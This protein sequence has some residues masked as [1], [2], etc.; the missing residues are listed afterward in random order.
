MAL[1][2]P[3]RLLTVSGSQA[4]PV[5]PSTLQNGPL[6][7]KENACPSSPSWALFYTKDVT[8][9]QRETPYVCDTKLT[10]PAL[11]QARFTVVVATVSHSGEGATSPPFRRNDSF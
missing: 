10:D 6:R 3:I 11:L 1:C 9:L 7:G 5:V 2:G 4:L 8:T